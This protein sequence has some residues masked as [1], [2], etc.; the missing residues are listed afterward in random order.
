[1]TAALKRVV[2]ESPYA[3]DITRNKTYAHLA[4]LDALKRGEAPIASHLIY[5][6]YLDDSIES[7]RIRGLECGYE[8]LRV[9]ELQAFY[10]DNGWSPGMLTALKIGRSLG[11]PH[12]VRYIALEA[13]ND[14][15][16]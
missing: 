14:T 7:E 12:I 6:H 10:I 16:A 5:P 8:W 1:M 11:I 3:G 4:M 13:P 9:A 15:T 2:V